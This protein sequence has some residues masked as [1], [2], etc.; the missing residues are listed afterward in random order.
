MI[1]IDD[2]KRFNDLWATGRRCGASRD[3]QYLLMR[4]VRGHRVPLRLGRVRPGDVSGSPH[5][6]L[7]RARTC[8]WCAAT[9]VEYEG[10]RVGPSPYRG[11]LESF[12][13]TDSVQAVCAPLTLP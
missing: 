12:P 8:E 5:T 3:G 1:D 10:R 4:P 6:V 2:F 13:I 9:R 7:N 11:Y